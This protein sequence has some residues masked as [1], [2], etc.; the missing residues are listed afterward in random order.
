MAISE[1]EMFSFQGRPH[2]LEICEA[3][4][5]RL[6]YAPGIF[7]VFVSSRLRDPERSED[8]AWRLEDWYRAKAV[9]VFQERVRFFEEI[10]RMRATRI[11]V[12]TLKSQWGSCSN[13]GALSFNWRLVFAPPA[14]LDYV[15][16]HEL[17]HISH[18]NHSRRF[19]SAVGSVFPDFPKRRAWLR[20]QGHLLHLQTA[21]V[22]SFSKLEL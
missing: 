22:V 5:G 17:T 8:I 14:I 7:K 9:E 21:P 20:T 6:E 13:Q 2:R 1:G 3:S 4:K 19:W 11:R 10:M 18:P 15:V 12:R 16:V